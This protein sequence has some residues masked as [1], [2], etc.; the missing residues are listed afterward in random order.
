MNE[1]PDF[2]G[3]IQESAALPLNSERGV[4]LQPIQD[5]VGH[6]LACRLTN[7]PLILTRNRINWIVLHQ[8]R[9]ARP[10]VST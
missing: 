1:G 3:S 8:T 6:T 9:L 5:I 2:D 4:I 10:K 7:F